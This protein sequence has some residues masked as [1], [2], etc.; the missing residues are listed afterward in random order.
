MKSFWTI[1]SYYSYYCTVLFILLHYLF[2]SH[3]L[4][5]YKVIIHLLGQQYIDNHSTEVI[6]R[7]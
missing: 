4:C 5:T 3:I 2:Y 1:H 7:S 6:N